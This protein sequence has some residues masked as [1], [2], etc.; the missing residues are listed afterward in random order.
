MDQLQICCFHKYFIFSK[1][2]ISSYKIAERNKVKSRI[3]IQ[4]VNGALVIVY[5]AVTK[6]ILILCYF[7][8]HFH[9]INNI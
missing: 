9:A 6:Y 4:V 5:I 1:I 3:V 8:F 2:E 7:K